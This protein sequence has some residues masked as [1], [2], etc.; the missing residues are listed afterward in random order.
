MIS[1]LLKYI[2]DVYQDKVGELN[3]EYGEAPALI[4]AML[5]TSISK[6]STYMHGHDMAEVVAGPFSHIGEL[7]KDV[8]DLEE[9]FINL[10]K[11]SS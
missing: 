7:E 5:D 6:C 8:A 2:S 10:K 1:L 4:A 11:R 9:Y 3:N